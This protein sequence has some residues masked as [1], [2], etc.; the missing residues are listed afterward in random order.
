MH[1]RSGHLGHALIDRRRQIVDID[2]DYA[3]LL[4]IPRAE[5]IGRSASELAHPQDRIMA[6]SF[7][8]ATWQDPDQKTH[9]GTI[10]CLQADGGILWINVTASRLGQG[11][12]AVLVV[13]ARLLCRQLETE[14][15]HAYWRMAR[16]LLQAIDGSKRAFGAPLAA[17][18]AC[19]I[20]LIAYLTEA[21]ANAV[22]AGELADRITTTWPLASRWINAL[23]DAGFV[24]AETPGPLDQ[25][26]PIRLSPL[27][28]SLLEALFNSLGSVMQG[29]RIPA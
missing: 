8:Q 28:L 29:P 17:N 22:A 19:E 24:E 14:S 6:D 15:V 3:A 2:D 26:T 25:A 9:R 13:S 11:D 20:L 16:L 21:E 10:R 23:I 5:V 12:A 4:G 7:L 1:T 18:P 27:A